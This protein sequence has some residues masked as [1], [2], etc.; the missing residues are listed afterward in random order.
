M[1]KN[2][3]TITIKNS[4]DAFGDEGMQLVTIGGYYIKDDK[5]YILYNE[6]EEL[7]MADCSVMLKVSADEVVVSRNGSFNSKMI[8]QEGKTTEFMYHLP[9]GDIQVILH[10]KK[11][12]NNLTKYG[13]SLQLIYSVDMQGEVFE[14]SMLVDVKTEA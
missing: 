6:N 10:T 8:Y 13:G 11:I 5:Y 4:S 1:E 14:H 9:Y 2:N 12:R 3:A 7:G